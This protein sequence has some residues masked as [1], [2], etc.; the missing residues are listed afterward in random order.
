MKQPFKVIIVKIFGN[1]CTTNPFKDYTLNRIRGLKKMIDIKKAQKKL[2][3]DAIYYHLIHNG[4]KPNKK[5]MNNLKD[6]N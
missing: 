6:N 1:T 2:Y 5:N 4:K 3:E